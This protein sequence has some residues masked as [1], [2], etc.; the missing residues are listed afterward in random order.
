MLREIQ[1]LDPV[2]VAR[3]L[4]R[5]VPADPGAHVGADDDLEVAIIDEAPRQPR[6][7]ELPGDR[8]GPEGAG[9]GDLRGGQGHPEARARPG[10]QYTAEEQT[11]ITPDVYVHKVGDKYFVID[12]DGG[13]PKLKISTSPHGA[14]AAPKA[15]EYIEEKLRNAQWLIR[16]IEQ[17]QRTIIRVTECIV[18]SQREFFEK[19]IAHLKPMILRDVAEAVGMHESTISRVTTNKYVHTPQGIFELKYFF[20]SCICRVAGEDIASEA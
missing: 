8:A 10:A 5:G 2:G 4:A 13:L 9:R 20:N 7:A 15:R 12:N 17:R 16:A 11:Y 19:G 14:P 1:E 3:A 6:E 18:G